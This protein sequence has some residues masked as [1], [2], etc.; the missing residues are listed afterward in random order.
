MSTSP[1]L[2]AL[3]WLGRQHW[4]PHGRDWMIRR[5]AHPDREADAP[6]EAD[7]F[8]LR[9]PG[10]LG[11]FIDWSVYFYGAFAFEELFLLR[12]IAEHRRGSGKPVT[13][14]DIGANIGHHTLFMSLHAD[15]IVAFEPFEAVRRK[16]E[17]KMAAN[18][19]A[20]V[21]LYPFALGAEDGSFPFYPPS[22]SNEGTGSLVASSGVPPIEVPVRRGDGVVRDEALPLPDIV[23]IDVEG[24]EVDVF[25]GL[26]ETLAAARP[27][28]LM[29]LLDDTRRRVGDADGLRALLYPDAEMFT[30]DRRKYRFDYRLRPFDFDRSFEVLVAPRGAVAAMPALAER[31]S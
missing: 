19:V 24:A 25:A 27:F 15:R 2:P 23:K 14:Y 26:R 9:Y 16:F 18:G 11:N 4:I 21:T 3:R 17:A 22:G 20:N 1:L 13:F 7:F 10:N 30:L 28:V 29:E 12:D 6:F 31:L 8:G 5:F